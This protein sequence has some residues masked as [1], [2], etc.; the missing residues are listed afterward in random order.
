MSCSIEEGH[1]VG[2]VK[3]GTALK[4]ALKTEFVYMY[5]QVYFKALF[6]HFS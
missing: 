3:P 6:C 1:E 5:I 4:S 2:V